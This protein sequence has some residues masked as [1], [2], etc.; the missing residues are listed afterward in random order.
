M[1][2]L[3]GVLMEL[4][5]CASRWLPASTHRRPE[6][7]L[8]GVDSPCWSVPGRAVGMERSDLLDANGAIFTVQGKALSDNAKP[9]AACSWS[10]TRP[11]PT[12]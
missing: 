1:G 12:P 9:P 7:G 6:R 10:A 8:Q 3:Q 2:A 5:D 11:T 4:N